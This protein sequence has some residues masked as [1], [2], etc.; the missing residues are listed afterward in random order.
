[1][2][3]SLPCASTSAPVAAGRAVAGREALAR[4]CPGRVLLE[5]L[6]PCLGYSRRVS[7]PRILTQYWDS[8]SPSPGNSPSRVE[9]APAASAS[10][11]PDFSSARSLLRTQ[12][13]Q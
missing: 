11:L 6:A 2:V 8:Q 10:S 3:L 13:R 9:A 5:R 7:G 4:V 1:M 12:A